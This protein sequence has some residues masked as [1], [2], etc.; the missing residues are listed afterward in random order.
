MGILQETP[1]SMTQCSTG[2]SVQLEKTRA[3]AETFKI[4]Y[5]YEVHEILLKKKLKAILVKT[6]ILQQTPF[7]HDGRTD[8]VTPGYPTP[9]FV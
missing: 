8:K 1:F 4:Q 7:F 5:D 2:H 3:H 9:N 6:G